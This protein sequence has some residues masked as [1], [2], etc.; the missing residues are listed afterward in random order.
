MYEVKNLSG[1]KNA[2]VRSICTKNKSIDRHPNEFN[3]DSRTTRAIVGNDQVEVKSTDRRK[4]RNET[5]E[6]QSM[7]D[8]FRENGTG[9]RV[10]VLYCRSDAIA[11]RGIERL[12]SD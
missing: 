4:S 12:T 8:A 5:V 6:Q 3:P 11:T 2:I 10:G 9:E 1:T 7:F